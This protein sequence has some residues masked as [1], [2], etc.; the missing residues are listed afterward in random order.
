MPSQPSNIERDTELLELCR[1]VYKLFP[2]WNNKE[3]MYWHK[4]IDY[5]Y[6]DVKLLNYGQITTRD[7]AMIC[8]LYTSDYLMEKLPSKSRVEKFII[9][10]HPDKRHKLFDQA[11]YNAYL[12]T[13]TQQHWNQ[14]N[15]P[16]KALLKL[17]IAL[18]D[19]GELNQQGTQDSHE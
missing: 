16:L 4:L 15:T 10:G 14:S 19:A 12:Y 7:G 9:M 5:D 17:A 8:P 13:A 2:E 18:N 1:K 6:Q 3:K 11:V